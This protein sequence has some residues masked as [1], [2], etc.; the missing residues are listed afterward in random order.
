MRLDSHARRRRDVRAS[1]AVEK[2]RFESRWIPRLECHPVR[3]EIIVPSGGMHD[4]ADENRVGR[5]ILL[6]F[7]TIRARMSRSRSWKSQLIARA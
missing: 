2:V 1:C 5:D 3:V 6:E 4:S 7:R